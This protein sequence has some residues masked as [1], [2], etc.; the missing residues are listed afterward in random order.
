M[1]GV[2][3]G[4]ILVCGVCLEWRR[5]VTTRVVCKPKC[6]TVCDNR[7]TY[8]V[9]SFPTYWLLLQAI[10]KLAIA[11][12]W[13]PLVTRTH[14]GGNQQTSQ[15]YLSSVDVAGVVRSLVAALY[16]LDLRS[17]GDAKPQLW[18]GLYIPT[19]VMHSLLRKKAD[20]FLMLQLGAFLLQQG[21]YNNNLHFHQWSQTA[22]SVRH[23][24]PR[25]VQGSA[26]RALTIMMY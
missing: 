10:T 14:P 25:P 19:P 12:A 18:C 4:L 21:G 11:S 26:G 9:C 24:M 22:R 20:S 7:V 5:E 13:Q 2:R 16:P 15:M 17:L 6:L 3:L 1:E 8:F 23:T